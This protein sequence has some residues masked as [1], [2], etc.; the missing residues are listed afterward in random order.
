VEE[1]VVQKTG[2]RHTPKTTWGDSTPEL[3]DPNKAK[4]KAPEKY[5]V[6]L[7][8]TAGD[9]VIEVNREWAPNGADRFYNM[10]KIGYF[11]DI[12]LF[13]A[14]PRFMIQFG[15]HG[16]PAIS[17]QWAEAK[18]QDDPAVKGVSN[19]PGMLT[20]ATAGPNTRTTQLFINLG[21]NARLDSQGFTPFGKIVEGMDAF[22]KI[23]T[24]YGEN[25]PGVQGNFQAKGNAF[26]SKRY[27]NLDYI[28]SAELLK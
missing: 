7:I 14:V 22:K 15:I 18:I 10:V 23:N 12:A 4:D 9:I 1:K 27:P 5:K 16:N 26:I 19:T 3:L 17:K 20:F 2:I 6:K 8:T 25:S 11:D 24:E 28:K 13:R 21:N